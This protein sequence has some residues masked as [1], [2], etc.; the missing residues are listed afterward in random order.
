MENNKDNMTSSSPNQPESSQVTPEEV[1]DYINNIESKST[2]SATKDPIAEMGEEDLKRLGIPISDSENQTQ[3]NNTSSE[4]KYVRE[5]PTVHGE[6]LFYNQKKYL[7][8]VSK[9]KVTDDEKERYLRSVLHDMCFFLTIPFMGNSV[10]L[11]IRAKTVSETEHLSKYLAEI[12]SDE[13]NVDLNIAMQEACKV[14]FLIQYMPKNVGSDFIFGEIIDVES[15]LLKSTADVSYAEFKQ[16]IDEK[17]KYL[18]KIPT[19]KWILCVN[20]LRIFDE[21]FGQLSEMVVNGDF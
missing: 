5:F 21:K 17:M 10:E 18:D 11:D 13:K 16:I 1:L 12:F 19:N 9:I 7:V 3:E 8:D 4:F 6:E 15:L 14:N 2:E 20:A